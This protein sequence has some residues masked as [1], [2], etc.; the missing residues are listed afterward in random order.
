[1]EVTIPPVLNKELS[2][3]MEILDIDEEFGS[4]SNSS[5]IPQI[6]FKCVGSF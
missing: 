1:M 5:K 2:S 4:S 3:R 6:L